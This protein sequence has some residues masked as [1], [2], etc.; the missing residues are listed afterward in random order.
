MMVTLFR[1]AWGDFVFDS[2]V[3]NPGAAPAAAL[4]RVFF[5]LFGVDRG[6]GDFLY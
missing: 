5:R 4:I 2:K 6:F 1:G 3:R